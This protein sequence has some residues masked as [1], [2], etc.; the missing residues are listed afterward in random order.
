MPEAER[1]RIQGL[2]GGRWQGFLTIAG[3]VGVVTAVLA[4]ST[5]GLAAAIVFD[6][7]LVAELIAGVLVAVAVL[8]GLMGY[9]R[10]AWG[11]A[12]ATRLFP[13]EPSR[14]Q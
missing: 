5:V 3:M 12:D 9:R 2:R 6:H 7:S 11:Q 8:V 1:L 14:V 10:S 4:G 13:D